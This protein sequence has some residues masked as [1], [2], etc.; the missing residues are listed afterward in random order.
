MGCHQF[1]REPI[2]TDFRYLLL[3]E[4]TTQRFHL[5]QVPTVQRLLASAVEAPGALKIEAHHLIE[6]SLQPR[7]WPGFEEI[8]LPLDNPLQC[9]PRR[10]N[11]SD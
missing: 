8:S 9:R 3:F 7:R 4:T 1:L 11:G 5:A 6:M 10:T 2:D